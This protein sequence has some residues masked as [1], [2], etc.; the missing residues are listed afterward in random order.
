ME[1][2]SAAAAVFPALSIGWVG[3]GD[4]TAPEYGTRDVD[5]MLDFIRCAARAR[6]PLRHPV[7]SGA[8]DDSRPPTDEPA[9]RL[10]TF[11]CRASLAVRR[12]RAVLALQRLVK[13]TQ[14]ILGPCAV[15]GLTFWRCRNEVIT[16]EDAAYLSARF[17][18]VC[19]DFD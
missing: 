10:V 2:A 18:T 17:A 13:E 4:A 14:A 12:P 19:I 1:A 16:P 5:A 9:V 6:R 3:A 11:A 8:P 7:R 15:V